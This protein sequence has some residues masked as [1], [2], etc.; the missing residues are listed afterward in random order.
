[1]TSVSILVGLLAGSALGIFFYG[2]LWLTVKRLPGAN[3]P[4][5]LALGSF[6][7][8][9]LVTVA[10]FLLLMRASWECAGSALVGFP[11]GRL[12]ISRFLPE[13]RPAPKCT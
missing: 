7:M 5:L 1:M 11:L 12:V 10:G 8:R 9:S 2:G 4:A 3:Y 13:R 6:W